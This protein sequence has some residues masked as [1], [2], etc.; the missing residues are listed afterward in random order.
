M[1]IP[2]NRQVLDENHTAKS[3][4]LFNYFQA[5][6]FFNNHGGKYCSVWAAIRQRVTDANLGN[7]HQENQEGTEKMAVNN[8]VLGPITQM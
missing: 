2:K 8:F 3:Y 5:I 4:R 7:S 1:N 6:P